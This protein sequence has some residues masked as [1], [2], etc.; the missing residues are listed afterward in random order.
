MQG[1]ATK[2][3][4]HKMRSSVDTRLFNITSFDILIYKYLLNFL[5]T[6]PKYC[7]LIYFLGSNFCGLRKTFT[8]LDS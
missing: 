3:T 4:Q 8:F 6:N 7:G 1:S 5:K 2:L